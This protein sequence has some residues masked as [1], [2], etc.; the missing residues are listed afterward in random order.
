[1]LMH[2]KKLFASLEDRRTHSQFVEAGIIVPQ[3]QEHVAGQQICSACADGFRTHMKDMIFQRC[4]ESG[5]DETFFHEFKGS[6]EAMRFAFNSPLSEGVSKYGDS[7]V[8][9]RM[10]IGELAEVLGWADELEVSVAQHRLVHHWPCKAAK[11]RDIDFAASIGLVI[12]GKLRIKHQ[13]P[14]LR[15]GID[16]FCDWGPNDHSIDLLKKEPYLV[17]IETDP[18]YRQQY[19][20]WL[21]HAEQVKKLSVLRPARQPQEEDS[22]LVAAS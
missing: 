13:I 21:E 15:V 8:W 6:G 1:M 2:K 16:L 19:E 3:R 17:M 20:S 4:L 14:D 22:L 11:S 18:A 10:N 9:G 5:G 12:R 7:D